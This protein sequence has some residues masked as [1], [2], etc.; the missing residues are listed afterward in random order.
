LHFVGHS[1]VLGHVG[2]AG[3][4]CGDLGDI[5]VCD[6]EGDHQGS[7]DESVQWLLRNLA[8]DASANPGQFTTV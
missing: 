8:A 3:Q 4:T 7:I 5:T 6:V 2:K 1:R